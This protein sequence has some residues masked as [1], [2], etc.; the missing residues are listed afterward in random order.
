MVVRDLTE[1]GRDFSQDLERPVVGLAQGLAHLLGR[2]PPEEERE[3]LMA[4]ARQVQ[5]LEGL[6]SSFAGTPAGVDH[7]A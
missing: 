5:A 7:A 2:R 1:E 4:M 6:R 3:I